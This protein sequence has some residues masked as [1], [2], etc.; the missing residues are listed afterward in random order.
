[1]PTGS[2]ELLRHLPVLVGND[3]V[4]GNESLEPGN[5][6]VDEGLVRLLHETEACRLVG[7][8]ADEHVNGPAKQVTPH[9]KG[10]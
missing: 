7:H 2:L 9:G 10:T 6:E 1:M 4:E 8:I 5:V 3:G